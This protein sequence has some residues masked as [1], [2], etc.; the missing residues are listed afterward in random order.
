MLQLN[1]EERQRWIKLLNLG[2]LG[3]DALLEM[4]WDLDVTASN[5]NL[6]CWCESVG[7]LCRSHLLPP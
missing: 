7:V 2:E 6:G 5:C 1:M 3:V 4:L